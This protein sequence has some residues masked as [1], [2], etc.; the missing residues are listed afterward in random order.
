MKLRITKQAVEV[1]LF[2]M[3]SICPITVLCGESVPRLNPSGSKPTVLFTAMG[4]NYSKVLRTDRNWDLSLVTLS[5]LNVVKYL[6][7][8]CAVFPSRWKYPHSHFTCMHEHSPVNP[9]ENDPMTSHLAKISQGYRRNMLFVKPV[10]VG[11]EPAQQHRRGS[12]E[13]ML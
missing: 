10:C 13:G 8:A 2:A 9:Q 7:R 12:L 4:L 6:G 5:L 1:K 11:T 3:L